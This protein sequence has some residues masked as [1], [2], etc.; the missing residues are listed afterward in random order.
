MIVG[1]KVL[2]RRDTPHRSDT[3]GHIIRSVP[4][5]RWRCKSGTS[6]GVCPAIERE[7]AG[8]AQ[9][10]DPHGLTERLRPRTSNTVEWNPV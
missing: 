3:M 4:P 1:R 9:E 6:S 10:V 2:T 5:S 7:A 8:P